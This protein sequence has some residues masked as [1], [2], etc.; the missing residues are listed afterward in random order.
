MNDRP[1]PAPNSDGVWIGLGIFAISL[2]AAHWAAVNP[3]ILARR[4]RPT[5]TLSEA[6]RTLPRIPSHLHDPRLAWPADRRATLPGPG[7]YQLALVIA[8]VALVA[9]TI[10]AAMVT[11]RWN[12][13]PEAINQ[14]TRLGVDTEPRLATTK[15]LKPLLLRRPEPGRFIVGRWGAAA[16]SPPR[17]PAHQVGAA[18]S[19]P[20]L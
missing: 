16:T 1:Q 2:G 8:G 4:P 12:R 9:L 19:A 17:R 10:T 6:L 7:A 18:S 5:I 20:S 14:R 15:D 3:S 13:K 11:S